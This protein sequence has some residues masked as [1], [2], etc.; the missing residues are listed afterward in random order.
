M[1]VV[2]MDVTSL[3]NSGAAA[4]AAAE[5]QKKMQSARNTPTRSRT[6]WDAGGYALPINT[7]SLALHSIPAPQISYDEPRRIEYET[8]IPPTQTHNFSDSQ[9]SLS[10]FTSSLQSATHSRFSSMSTV[11][12]RHPLER[13]A[14]VSLSPKLRNA[15]QALELAPDDLT[16]GA[17]LSTSLSPTGSLDAHTLVAQQHSFPSP[18]SN[19]T[20][21]SLAETLRTGSDTRSSSQESRAVDRPGSPSDAIL[22]KRSAVPILRVNTSDA[23]LKKEH[24]PQQ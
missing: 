10:S 11:N 16:T 4:A 5:Q 19:P 8:P 6:P 12:S 1:L 15:S 2:G 22:I 3:L 17:Y 13:L 9:S 18:P 14:L 21:R 7:L 23:D 24:L 20:R